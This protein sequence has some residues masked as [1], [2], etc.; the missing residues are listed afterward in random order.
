MSTHAEIIKQLRD[1]TGVSLGKCQEA[2]EQ[3]DGDIEKARELLREASAGLSAKK[4]DRTL[5]AGSI[6]SYI[7]S[8]LQVGTLLEMNCET[9]FV[10]KTD[11]FVQLANDVALHITA[12]GSMD[13]ESL[14]AEPFVKNPEITIAQYIEETIQKTGERIE[15]GT[16]SRLT[17]L[18]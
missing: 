5:G 7:H 13:K 14:L 10:A 2:V 1:E 18:G 9:D 17:V 8:N 11:A 3:A 4:A 12:M 15:V 16:F 6:T